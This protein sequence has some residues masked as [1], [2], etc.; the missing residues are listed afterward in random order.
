M[1]VFFSL[2]VISLCLLLQIVTEESLLAMKVD[3]TYHR[4]VQVGDEVVASATEVSRSRRFASYS[5]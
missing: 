4:G 3:V 5:T 2:L 1:V